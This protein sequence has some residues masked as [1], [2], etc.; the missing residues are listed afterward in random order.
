[1][2]TLRVRKYQ[3]KDAGDLSKIYYN[4]IHQI[5]KSNYNEEQL[6]AW[7]PSDLVEYYSGW[8][9]KLAKIKP[10]IATIGK[11]IVGFAE[12]EENG[13]IDCFYV[14]HQFQGKKIGSKLIEE[15]EK[16]AKQKNIS[17]IYA[18]VSITAK[19]FFEKKRI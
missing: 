15:I 12:F 11:Q 17:K 4:T 5:C 14:H 9:E 2:T 6:N 13:H 18:E 1:M 10:L 8:K 7:A 16:I 3:E 19:P